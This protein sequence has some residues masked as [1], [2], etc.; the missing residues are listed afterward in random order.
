MNG[1]AACSLEGCVV[2]FPALPIADQGEPLP[3]RDLLGSLHRRKIE[4]CDRIHVVN[5]DGY[6]GP[7]TAS[8]IAYAETLDKRI[9]YEHGST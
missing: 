5:P 2:L 9:T 7:S 6:V 1:L 3:V 8:E 4:M